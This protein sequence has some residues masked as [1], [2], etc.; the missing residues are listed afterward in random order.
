MNRRIPLLLIFSFL[1]VIFSAK[2]QETTSPTAKELIPV[3]R[4]N[5]YINV[6]FGGFIRAE[7]YVDSREMAGA[8]DDLFCF[9]PENKKL[10]ADGKD[11]NE[12]VRQNIS[13]QAS[14]FSALINGPQFLNA[15]SSSYFEFDF[16]GGNAINV[17][18]RQAW[19]KL[20]WTKGT[21]LFGKTWN[22]FAESPFP[23]VVGLHTGVP[24]RPF[25]RADQLRFT[26]KPIDNVTLLLAGVY[27]TEHKSQY[28]PSLAG[29][30]RANPIPEL[31]FQ[32][33]YASPFISAGVMSEFKGIKPATQTTGEL[34]TFKT[35]ETLYTYAFS[36]YANMNISLFNVR[37]GAVYGQ[38]LSEYFMQGGYAVR[39]LNPETGAKTYTPSN[40]A[41]AWLNLNYGKKWVVGVFGGYQKNL[42]FCNNPLEDGAFYGRWQNIDHI[43]RISPSL[44][45]NIRQWSFQVEADYNVAAYGKVDFNDKGKVKDAD[46]V[47]GVRAI[48]AT[49]FYY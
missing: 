26:Y 3:V 48:F 32:V 37:A 12:V 18:V 33:R 4:F 17:R 14:R 44:S 41:T 11:L 13:S 1:A 22:P 2:A 20:A 30:I 15:G 23:N 35:N 7:Y 25:N 16:T 36:A 47:G 21:V 5:D 46:E 28:D 49:T 10:G 31:H 42:G 27:Q 43:W 38:N 9:F 45:Y 29:D 40:A 24:F 19:V 6:K 34:G 8:L 39:T